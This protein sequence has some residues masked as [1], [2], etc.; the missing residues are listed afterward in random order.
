MHGSTKDV[1]SLRADLVYLTV[2]LTFVY[3]ATLKDLVIKGCDDSD[4][5]SS[6][7]LSVVRDLAERV[8]A[9]FVSVTLA[10]ALSEF[11]AY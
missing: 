9:V 10:A 8:N 7:A 11:G 3:F 6:I 5:L 4:D 1:F 2:M